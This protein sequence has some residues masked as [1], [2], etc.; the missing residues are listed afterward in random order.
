MSIRKFYFDKK[1]AVAVLSVA[2]PLMM[3][4]LITCSVNLIDNLM[5]GQLGDIAIGGVAAVNR[6]YMI[7][8]YGT[9][10]LIAA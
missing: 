3:Q 5:V 2:I 8:T 1:F 7:A 6:F 10:G 4:Q 9:N